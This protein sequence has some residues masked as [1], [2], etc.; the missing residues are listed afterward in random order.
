MTVYSNTKNPKFVK[1][2][3]TLAIIIGSICVVL[4]LFLKNDFKIYLE[5]AGFPLFYAGL[6]L[7]QY[8]LATYTIDEESDAII[9]NKNKKYPMRISRL[10]TVKYKENRKGKFRSLFLHD[11]GVGF[12]DI[13]TTKENADRMVAQLLKANPSI[14]VSHTYHCSKCGNN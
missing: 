4:H 9:N 3:S 8:Y 11:D 12:M 13:R 2:A 5:L 10:K 6:L 14:E 1:W 7:G